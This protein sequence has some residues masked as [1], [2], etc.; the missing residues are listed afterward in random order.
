MQNKELIQVRRKKQNHYNTDK[1]LEQFF[2]EQMANRFMKKI[3]TLLITRETQV[4]KFHDF[5]IV[6]FKKTKQTEKLLLFP[7]SYN[8]K[9]IKYN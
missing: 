8:V 4:L 6:V 2:Q 1:W 7:S 5:N 3:P 9:D